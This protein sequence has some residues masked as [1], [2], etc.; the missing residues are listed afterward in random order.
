[1]SSETTRKLTPHGGS[2]QV[3]LPRAWLKKHNLQP[4]DEVSIISTATV[5]LI[6]VTREDPAK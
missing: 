3:G 4:G 5:L 1:M 2:L 6:K